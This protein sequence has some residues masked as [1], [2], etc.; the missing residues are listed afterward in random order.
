MKKQH[1]A[2]LS[3]AAAVVAALAG[4]NAMADVTVFGIADGGVMTSKAPGS[5]SRST[6]FKS[7]GMSTSAFGIKGSEDLGDGVK[8]N[9]GLSAFNAE[10]DSLLEI[11]T[12]A[13]GDCDPAR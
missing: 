3:L 11:R 1:F 6:A 5:T 8:A 2:K 13:A 9:F 12:P 7:G 10:V 4:G